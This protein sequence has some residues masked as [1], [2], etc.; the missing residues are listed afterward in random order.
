MFCFKINR[1]LFLLP[2]TKLKHCNVREKILELFF[3]LI[4]CPRPEAGRDILKPDFG[5]I[6][7]LK[8]SAR[9]LN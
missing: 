8:T 4:Q 1:P 3:I 6:I 2:V 9:A 7:T 5:N